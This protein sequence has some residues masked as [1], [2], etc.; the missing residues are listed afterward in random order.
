MLE[1]LL[2][3]IYYFEWFIIAFFV[4]LNLFYLLL[5]MISSRAMW[6]HN[7]QY[8]LTRG[9]HLSVRFTKPFSIIVPAYNEGATIVDS[10][11]SFLSLDYPEY[12]VIVANDG[13]TDDTLNRLK[14]TYRLVA[15]DVETD[16]RYECAPIHAVYFSEIEPRLVVVDKE[17]GGKA[18]AQ[19]ASANLARYPY[20][21]AVDADSL[22]SCDSMSKI[23]QRFTAAPDNVAVG[24]IIRLANGCTIVEGEVKEVNMPH[25]FLERIQVVEYLR[26]FLFGR[27]GWSRL[28]ILMIVSGAFG[29]FRQDLLTLLGGWNKDTVGEDLDIVVR[30]HRH[31][32]ENRLPYSLSFAPDPVCWTQAPGTIKDLSSQRDRWQRG[33]METLFANLRMFFNPRYGTIGL[34]G[35]PYFF[36]FEMLGALVEFIGYPIIIICF[37]LGIVDKSFF[38]L[39]LAVAIVWGMCISYTAVALEEVSYRRYKKRSDIWRLFAAGFLENFGY[40]QLHSFWRLK[41]MLKYIFGT[42]SGWGVIKRSSFTALFCL[43]V[44][45]PAAAAQEPNYDRNM[46]KA[47]EFRLSGRQK[48]AESIYNDILKEN[49]DDTDA[50]VG[51]GFCRLSKGRFTGAADDFNRAIELAPD[52][53]DAYVGKAILH[54]RKGDRGSALAALEVCEQA[55]GKD[56]NKQRYLAE[57]S[58]REGHFGFARGLDSRYGVRPGRKL[59]DYPNEIYL[60]ASLDRL[61]RGDDWDST[62]ITYVR[63]H[64]PDL[65]WWISHTL[66]GRYDD[67]DSESGAGLAFRPTGRISLALEGYISD[68]EDFLAE[69]KYKA[70]ANIEILSYTI[71]GLGADFSRYGSDWSEVGRLE[72]TRYVGEFYGKY[73]LLAGNDSNDE[74]VSTSIFEMGCEKELRYSIRIGYAAGNESVEE[75]TGTEFSQDEI[76]TV[77]GSVRYYVT[78]EWGLIVGGSYEWRDGDPF[79]EGGSLSAFYRF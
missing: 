16:N 49:P 56:Q 68:A 61:E 41:G 8:A 4:S 59:V 30:I 75:G 52:Y 53:V 60:N 25:G 2:N 63:R 3:F 15:V 69:Y 55:L 11:K 26:A 40:R 50:L 71:L 28:N 10:V 17:N 31:I 38:L 27:V 7:V 79:R 43:L 47:R 24:G 51:R 78:P 66:Y 76:D 20:V 22:L 77:F 23:M 46:R 64:R 9:T 36:I 29:V 45:V 19:N 70:I 67:S 73:T 33:L 32:R 58:W 54:R 39:F 74:N 72:L 14:E 18:D 44:L 6:E 1:V 34:I 65:T 21:C 5:L 62:G 13:S 35:Y 48:E 42:K 12:E 37:A 57:S